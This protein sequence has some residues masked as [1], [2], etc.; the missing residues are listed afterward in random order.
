MEA[1]CG[2]GANPNEMGGLSGSRGSSIQDLPKIYFQLC[3]LPFEACITINTNILFLPYAKPMR[4]FIVL[5][6]TTF[7]EVGFWYSVSY[8]KPMGFFILLRVSTSLEVGFGYS[9]YY[10]K[11][12]RFFIVLR[13]TSL[14][15]GFWYPVSYAKP[16]RFFTV[17][18]EQRLSKVGFWSGV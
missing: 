11:P 5:R 15:V 12:M 13:V 18:R 9:G 7:P 2:R 17:L 16:M 8:A 6:V 3:L 1:Y 4:F 14:E 10:A